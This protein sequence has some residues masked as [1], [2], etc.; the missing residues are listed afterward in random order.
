MPLG[1]RKKE[2]K[3]LKELME[4]FAKSF[5][6]K[7]LKESKKQLEVLKPIRPKDLVPISILS[8]INV[9]LLAFLAF[10]FQIPSKLLFRII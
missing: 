6:G 2:V 1:R 4:Y 5:T 10:I 8:A 9:C 7:C 3:E